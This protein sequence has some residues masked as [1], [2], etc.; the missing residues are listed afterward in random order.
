[1][2]PGAGVICDGVHIEALSDGILPLIRKD[3]GLV[4]NIKY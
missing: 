1:M 2:A 4:L 3:E